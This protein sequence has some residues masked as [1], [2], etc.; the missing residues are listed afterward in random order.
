MKRAVHTVRLENLR[1]IASRFGSHA[2]L[3]KR[4]GKSKGWV[5]QLIGVNPT[6]PVSER[7]ARDVEEKLGLTEGVLDQGQV[8]A[9]NY[10]PT[11]S[12]AD[13]A[14]EVALARQVGRLVEDFLLSSPVDREQILLA[15]SRAANRSTN[16]A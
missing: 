12:A 9:A 2:A 14:R 16:E 15:A 1:S 11:L 8:V 5:S 10:L 7:I 4:L 6:T 3:A 13:L